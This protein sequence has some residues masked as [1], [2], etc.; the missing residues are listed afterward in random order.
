LSV[1][2]AII[3]ANVRTMNPK[4]PTAHALAITRNRIVKIGTNKEI[5]KLIGENTKVLNL[6]GKT[7]VPGLIDTHIHV[8]DFGRCLMWL[9]LTAAAS[10]SELQGVLKEKAAQTAEGKWIVGR[11]WNQNRFKEKRMPQTADLDAVA[12]DNPVI[13]YH[14]TAMICAANT[15][16]QK[17]AGIT[18]QTAVPTGGTID[19]NPRTGELMGIF[20]DTAA[21]LIWK[22]VPEPTAD[23]LMEAVA[24]ACQ[25]ISAAGL[26]SVHWLVLLEVEIGIIQKLYAFG[27]LPFR[28]NM[29][30]PEAL[31]EKA[32]CLKTN[33]P[34]VLRFGGVTVDVDGYLDSKEAALQ[35]PYSDDPSNRGK[36]L[37]PEEALAASVAKVLAAGV[38]P[39]ILAMGDR[40]V[41]TAL[42][43]IE[44]TPKSDVCFRIEQ[45]AV[46]NKDLVKSLKTQKVIVSIQ[47]KVISTE[48]SVWSAMQRLGLERA[49]WLHPLKTLLDAGVKVAGGSDCPMEPLSPLLG[50]QEVVVREAFPEQRLS[51]MEALCMYT[52]DAAYSSGEENVKGSIEEGKIADLTVLNADPV[53]V[54]PGKIKDIKVELVIINGKILIV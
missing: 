44:Q 21:S 39:I 1:D 32:A 12:S 22:A 36:L 43:V 8:A 11:G 53:S 49:R 47:P 40:A 17:L 30:V 31:M 16:A 50:M 3:N 35:E 42:K 6:D 45:A 24:F 4:Q 54:E 48:F 27:R 25:K 28:V 34:S 51:A 13:L 29:V 19:K 33:D 10:I 52:L 26:T 5:A 18:N 14:E 2:L 38:Q 41:D 37:L 9:D 20:R 46:L 15:K 23:E 7:V